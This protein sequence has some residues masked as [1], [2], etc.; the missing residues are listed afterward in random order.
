MPAFK[1]RKN[2]LILLYIYIYI[3]SLACRRCLRKIASAH[4][5]YV[6]TV[7]ETVWDLETDH[8]VTP[9]PSHSLM[10]GLW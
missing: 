4:T 2:L 6:L 7:M 5:Y 3:L 10:V 8:L 1:K 9:R